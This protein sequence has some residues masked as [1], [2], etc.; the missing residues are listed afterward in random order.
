MADETIDAK[1]QNVFQNEPSRCASGKRQWLLRQRA[2]HGILSHALAVYGQ[3]QNLKAPA[4]DA[5]GVPLPVHAVQTGSLGRVNQRMR[6]HARLQNP[7][8]TP[9]YFGKSTWKRGGE[10]AY[11]I[12]DR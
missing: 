4:I 7:K 5:V 10:G 11:Q 9:V 12:V 3:L 6:I 2:R 1:D 8:R